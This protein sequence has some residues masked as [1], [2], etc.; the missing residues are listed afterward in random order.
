MHPELL[1]MIFT[2]HTTS[3]GTSIVIN[4]LTFANAGTARMVD[5]RNAVAAQLPGNVTQGPVK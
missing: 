2:M 5:P 3:P 4:I 1:S